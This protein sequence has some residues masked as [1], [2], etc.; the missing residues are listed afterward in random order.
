MARSKGKGKLVKERAG[1]DHSDLY[2]HDWMRSKRRQDS[3][4]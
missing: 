1:A 3:R 2:R 4:L